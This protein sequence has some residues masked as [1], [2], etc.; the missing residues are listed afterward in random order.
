MSVLSCEHTCTTIQ[1]YNAFQCFIVTAMKTH[2]NK[3]EL[4]LSKIVLFY[5]ARYG[6]REVTRREDF[7]MMGQLMCELKFAT[8]SCRK[9]RGHQP[10][11]RDSE[12]SLL[13]QNA[14]EPAIMLVRSELY[15]F[16]RRW[17]TQ[18]KVIR[19]RKFLLETHP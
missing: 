12:Y 5:L 11:K 9:R 7:S 6:P 3:A 17:S 8:F 18:D 16:V 15:L 4:I 14:L 19:W 1:H 2:D 10:D 13:L